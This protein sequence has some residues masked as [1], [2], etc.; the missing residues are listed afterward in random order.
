M[1]SGPLF[2]P[3]LPAL[4]GAVLR[5]TAS[6]YLQENIY[7][8]CEYSQEIFIENVHVAIAT[9]STTHLLHLLILGQRERQ[10]QRVIEAQCNLLGLSAAVLGLSA[11]CLVA[12]HL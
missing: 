9:V 10:H 3:Q 11:E 1:L 12:V 4:T 8:P 2:L 7:L 5:S 6:I